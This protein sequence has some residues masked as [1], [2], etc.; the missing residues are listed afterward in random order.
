MAL[1]TLV[2]LRKDQQILIAMK[3]RGFGE[4]LLNGVGGKVD[5]GESIEDAMIRECQEEISVTPTSY[6]KVAVQ[7]FTNDQLSEPWQQEV[8]TFF[9]DKWEGEPTESEEM[10]PKWYN[11]TEIPYANMW[12]DDQMWLPLVLQGKLLKASVSFD[13]GNTIISANI[14]VVDTL[15][16]S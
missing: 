7:F 4:G 13:K 15:S 16:D 10:A 9:C 14:T 3:K 2:F 11:Q 6:Q 12:Q 5:K 1:C 8:H